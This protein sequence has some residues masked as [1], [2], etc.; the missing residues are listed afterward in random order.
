MTMLARPVGPVVAVV[1]VCGCR[2]AA[3][4]RRVQNAIA[5]LFALVPERFI[6]SI[7]SYTKP[8]ATTRLL[9]MLQCEP[10]LKTHKHTQRCYEAIFHGSQAVNIGR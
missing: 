2:P 9:Y 7:L 1:V 10:F 6:A 8:I 4:C 3:Y 5:Q